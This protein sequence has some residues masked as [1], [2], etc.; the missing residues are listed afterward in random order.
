MFFKVED[1]ANHLRNLLRTR[2]H[3]DYWSDVGSVI[4]SLPIYATGDNYCFEIRSF[5]ELTEPPP[6]LFALPAAGLEEHW[7][8]IAFAQTALEGMAGNETLQ[9]FSATLRA[10]RIEIVR[11]RMFCVANHVFWA[12]TEPT[13]VD[14]ASRVS[15]WLAVV[16]SDRIGYADEAY[17][18]EFT[19]PAGTINRGSA[20]WLLDWLRFRYDTLHRPVSIDPRYRDPEADPDLSPIDV[21]RSIV[22]AAAAFTWQDYALVQDV[23]ARQAV[24][25]TAAAGQ[26]LFLALQSSSEDDDAE[27]GPED[28]GRR[29]G[30]ERHRHTR[31]LKDW[32]LAEAERMTGSD[33]SIARDLAARLPPQFMHV[34]EDPSRLI[35]DAIREKRV[36]QNGRRSGNRGQSG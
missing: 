29:G 33:R 31:A 34:S 28:W 5:E 4:E 15:D 17:F 32:A 10:A 14:Y 11:S 27:E 13:D 30:L 6:K 20:T 8:S 26:A 1:L 36:E 18:L 2:S 16:G 22:L 7:E 9:A 35:Y 25:L 19:E 3:S 23:S 21:D 12:A 24:Q